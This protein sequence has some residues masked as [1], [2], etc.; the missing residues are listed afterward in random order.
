MPQQTASSLFT[1]AA[2]I[3]PTTSTQD[4]TSSTP[5]KPQDALA[6]QKPEDESKNS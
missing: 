3:T 1:P 2:T 6:S 5:A 4:Q